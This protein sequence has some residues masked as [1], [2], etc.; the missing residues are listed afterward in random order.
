MCDQARTLA[1]CRWTELEEIAFSEEMGICA[2]VNF[3]YPSTTHLLLSESLQFTRN[4]KKLSIKYV[5]F[6]KK[7][8]NE[9]DPLIKS[10][11]TKGTAIG[12]PLGGHKKRAKLC[13]WKNIAAVA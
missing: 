10:K 1:M 4:G 7:W 2:E 5:E 3:T 6:F 13:R 8:E 12:A 11:Q 9:R